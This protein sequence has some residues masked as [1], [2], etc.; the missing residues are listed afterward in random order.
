MDGTILNTIDDITDALN[1]A[2]G[3]LGYKNDFTNEL[4][5][6]FVGSGIN[7]E[8]KRCIAYQKGLPKDRLIDV[9]TE[10]D[11]A[12]ALVSNEEIEKV[13]AVLEPYY[14]AHCSIKTGPYCGIK[15]LITEL[16]KHG[17]ITVV[18]SNKP[19]AA[20]QT[21]SEE[22]FTGLFD[23]SIGEQAGIKRKPAPDMT[24]RALKAL[25]I[26]KGDAV[27]IGDSEI[28][29][30]TAQNAGLDCIC[31]AWGFRGEAF[32]R[33]HGAENIVNSPEEILRFF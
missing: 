31:V 5:K 11:P 1:Y 3:S 4:V 22:V 23:L 25:G 17:I 29:I 19:D 21:L 30:E 28:D 7:I 24:D 14:D 27:Y 16:R 8:I 9:G 26:E 13:K 32:L 15:E 18:V 2:L 12:D 10:N 20:V 6:E 33:A